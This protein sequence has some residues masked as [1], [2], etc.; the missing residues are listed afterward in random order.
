MYSKYNVLIKIEQALINFNSC[1][2]VVSDEDKNSL[3]MGY[4]DEYQF[5]GTLLLFISS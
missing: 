4:L 2:Y 3:K 5:F 1:R